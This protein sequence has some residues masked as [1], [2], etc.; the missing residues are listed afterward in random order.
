VV[1]NPIRRRIQEDEVAVGLIVRLVRSGEIARVARAT[2]HDFLFIDTQHATFSR[3]SVSEIISVAVGC[4][5]APLVRIRRY[6][7]SDASVYL[8]AGGAGVII[9][10]V[11]TAEQARRAVEACRFPPVGR[12]SLP[13]PPVP[14]ELRDLSQTEAMRQVNAET[15][16]VCMIESLE[17]LN[18][19]DEIAATDGVDV[20]YVGCVDLLLALGKPGEYGCPEVLEAIDHVARAART[21]GR[22]LGIGGDRDPSRRTRYIREGARFLSTGTDVAMLSAEAEKR[23]SSI[24]DGSPG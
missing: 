5:V 16:I 15:L 14:P 7:D 13:G 3:E 1:A 17:G 21:H 12:R 10:N 8:D 22:I 18:N 20:L 9:P 19:V 2:G 23:V 6:D 4:G 11:H 24:R